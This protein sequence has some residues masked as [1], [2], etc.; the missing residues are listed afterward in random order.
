V[1]EKIE[2]F[3]IDHSMEFPEPHIEPKFNMKAEIDRHDMLNTTTKVLHEI[4]EKTAKATESLVLNQLNDFVS[5][6]LIVI[7]K[8]PMTMMQTPF[9]TV[10]F[11]QSV[12]LVLKDREYIEKL[13]NELSNALDIIHKLSD[14]SGD[15][16]YIK[17]VKEEF[18]LNS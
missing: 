11:K 2:G 5:R 9:G 12:N 7:E 15:H 16:S 8:G 1:F 13:E 17:R 3:M 18:N 14:Y 10:E 4:S 6:G